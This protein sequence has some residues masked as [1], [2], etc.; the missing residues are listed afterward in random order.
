MVCIFIPYKFNWFAIYN[1]DLTAWQNKM[2]RGQFGSDNNCSN[3]I[4]LLS[5]RVSFY[6]VRSYIMLCYAR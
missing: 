5:K 6:I 3:G 2:F 4:G 1:T